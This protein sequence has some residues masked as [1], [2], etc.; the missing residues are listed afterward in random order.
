TII[1]TPPNLI[2]IQM[3]ELLFPAAPTVTFA[4]WILLGLPIAI[5]ILISAWVIVCKI[6]FKQA[7]HF[8]MNKDLIHDEYQ[9]LGKMSFEEKTVLAVFATTALLW[10][11]RS[12]IQIGDLH[13][14]GWANLF[15]KSDFITDGSVAVMMA[16]VLFFIP[17]HDSKDERILDHAVFSQIPWDIILFFGGGFALAKGIVDS[18]LSAYIAS[19]FQSMAQISGFSM[20]ISI[21]SLVTFMTELTSNVATTQMLL[22]IL[23]ALA[24]AMQINPILLMITATISA[25]MAFM[26]P[27][28][29]APNAI[30][31]GSKQIHVIDMVKAGFLINLTGIVII[32][33][34]VYFLAAIVFDFPLDQFPDWATGMGAP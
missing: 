28:A 6:A 26:M 24:K 31:F 14:Y 17:S 25:S 16:T 15:P 11:T 9:K 1:G 4:E 23:A 29:T 7:T 10:V 21:A 13:L 30:I 3:M 22:P 12:D 32:S 2:F 8:D 5:L 20:I 33:L 18:G 27:V 19:S 34:I